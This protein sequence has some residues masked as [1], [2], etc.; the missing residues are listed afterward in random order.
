MKSGNSRKRFLLVLATATRRNR[1]FGSEEIRRTK[2]NVVIPNDVC[3][4]IFFSE[5]G[6][7]EHGGG[8]GGCVAP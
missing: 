5:E 1:I 2:N 8:P 7:G 4:K 3:Y 6:E